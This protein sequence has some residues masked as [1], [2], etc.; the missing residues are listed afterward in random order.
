MSR[1]PLPCAVNSLAWYG[2]MTAPEILQ[3]VQ[4][5]DAPPTA[6]R[7]TTPPGSCTRRRCLQVGQTVECA[8][9]AW[10]RQPGARLRVPRGDERRRRPVRAG[11]DLQ[12]PRRRRGRRLFCRVLAI[13]R[14]RHH[15]RR[16]GG[17]P[18]DVV[19]AA[20]SS[21]CSRHRARRGTT[22]TFRVQAPRLGAAVRQ[23][24]RLRGALAARR[25]QGVP[26]GDAGRLEPDGVDAAEGEADGAGRAGARV[27]DAR[28]RPTAAR[29]PRR[30]SCRFAEP[31]TRARPEPAR[32]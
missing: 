9:G 11:C 20:V 32:P 8:A 13:E 5:N 12:A 28:R 23:G 15:V 18:D 10:T 30:R 1:G 4:G 16:V 7:S 21:T 26:R 29:R 22:V 2:N 27:G 6:P 19:S 31:P 17:S 24:R 3:F 14:R 25:R